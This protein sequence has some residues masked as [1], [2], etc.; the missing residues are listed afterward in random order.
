MAF[1]QAQRSNMEFFLPL[2]AKTVESS[3]FRFSTLS[4]YRGWSLKWNDCV[5][6]SGRG[7][8]EK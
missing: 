6:R 2:P 5:G 4:G 1:I 7:D 8:V 3:D